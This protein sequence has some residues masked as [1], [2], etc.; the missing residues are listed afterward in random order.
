MAELDGKFVYRIKASRS[1]SLPHHR[2][3]FALLH[4]V[5]ERSGAID[6][7]PSFDAFRDI[8]TIGCGHF[9]WMEAPTGD[10]WPR[11]KSIA[12]HKMDQDGFNQFFDAA[13]VVIS[14]KLGLVDAPDLRREFEEMLLGEVA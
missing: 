14:D 4:K 13:V 5:Y 8:V 11:A 10:R 7:F 3:F 1:R 6:R 2:L 9:E 12:F